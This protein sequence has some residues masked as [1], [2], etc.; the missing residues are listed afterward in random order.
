MIRLENVTRVYGQGARAVT[1]LKDVNLEV[2]P[3]SITG[4]IGVSGAG[5]STLIRCVNLLERPTRGRVFVAGQELTALNKDAL[6]KARHG[7]GMIFQHFNL[8]ESRT[9]R[10]NIG[11]PLELIGTPR[12]DIDQ[13]IDELLALTGLDERASAYPAALSGGQKQR[14]AIARALAS[15]PKALLCDEATSALDPQTTSSILALLRDI[16]QRLGL[17]ILLITHEMEVVRTICDQVALISG[18]AL[19]ETSP[20][21]DFFTRPA[22]EEGR[23]FLNDFL[24]LAP[25]NAL[26]QRLTDSAGQDSLPVV[27]LTFRGQSLSSELM[28]RLEQRFG[29]RLRI[30]QARV[31]NIQG[32]TLGLMIVELD[33]AGT[34]I[35]AAMDHLHTLDVQT[36]VLGHVQRH[37]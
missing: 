24:Q 37:D 1:A 11:L 22:T 4:V 8:L 10:G 25:S 5:K 23:V 29:I 27:R 16:N 34:T 15:N 7:I 21:G 14:V 30:L 17:T 6:R 2:A 3:G 13:R 33:G 12:R 31:E 26:L 28:T 18:G 19:V 9:V 32:R 35:N 36:E 20:V